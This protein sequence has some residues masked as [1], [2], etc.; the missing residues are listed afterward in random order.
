MTIIILSSL[1][2][3]GFSSSPTFAVETEPFYK[4]KTIRIVVGL[5]PGGG[6]DR[7]ARLVSRYMGKYIPGSP[8]MLVQKDDRRQLGHRR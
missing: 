7:A 6:Y 3:W 2:S 4:N 1:I 8:M 5:I